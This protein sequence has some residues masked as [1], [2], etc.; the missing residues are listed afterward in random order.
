M[1]VLGL[2]FQ[3]LLCLICG[4][5]RFLMFDVCYQKHQRRI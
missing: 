4:G 3:C 2:S 1:A 5:A